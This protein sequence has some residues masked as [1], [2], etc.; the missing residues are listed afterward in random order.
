METRGRLRSRRSLTLL[1]ISIVAVGAVVAWLAMEVRAAVRQRRALDES[2]P[3]CQWIVFTNRMTGGRH[4]VAG[5]AFQSD[6]ESAAANLYL[7]VDEL[8]LSAAEMPSS[9]IATISDIK[10][11]RD[12]SLIDA[13]DEII[14]RALDSTPN[15]EQVALARCR[16]DDRV[17]LALG[18]IERL[19][20]LRLL[21]GQVSDSAMST[22]C[23]LPSIKDF[24]LAACSLSHSAL[25]QLSRAQQLESLTLGVVPIDQT[26]ASCLTQLVSLRK[27]VIERDCLAPS[28]KLRFQTLVE[29]ERLEVFDYEVG[30]LDSMS[31]PTELKH[32]VLYGGDVS[33]E[34][35]RTISAEK[36]LRSL[37]LEVSGLD[38]LSELRAAQQ[39]RELTLVS[40]SLSDKDIE[41]LKRDLPQCTVRRVRRPT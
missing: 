20:E 41:N 19:R 10:G 4:E 12:L 5:A 26:V 38:G 30:Q 14:L 29:L 32:L 3:Y 28:V 8:V 37:T 34:D 39:L 11:L 1:G 17:A 35:I 40:N 36:N 15:L 25:L 6:R 24:E 9:T 13:S 7:T 21:G 2:A 31:L 33:A 22:L 27:L 23:Q 16:I 18:K